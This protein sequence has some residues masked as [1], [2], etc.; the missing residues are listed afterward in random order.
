MS[1]N[2]GNVEVRIVEVSVEKDVKQVWNALLGSYDPPLWT[3]IDGY[4][5][6]LEKIAANAVT[7]GVYRGKQLVG[8]ASFYANDK[9]SRVGFITQLAVA[10]LSRGEGLGTML[11]N[12]VVE[13]C[14]AHGMNRVSLEVSDNNLPAMALYV[15]N[16]FVVCGK[17]TRGGSF[18]EKEIT[19]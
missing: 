8:A 15:R 12:E 14:R 1:V 16:G 5:A 7:I 18:L 9:N 2:N 19:T 4:Q 10:S 3:K 13:R 11:L 17:S 6:Y